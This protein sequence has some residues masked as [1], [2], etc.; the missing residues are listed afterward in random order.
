MS[1]RQ[2]WLRH[3]VAPVSGEGFSK[4]LARDF[5]PHEDL[6]S[7][8]TAVNRRW[9]KLVFV[10][11]TSVVSQL[12][13]PLFAIAGCIDLFIREV[14]LRWWLIGVGGGTLVGFAFAIVIAT[15]TYASVA[16]KA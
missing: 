11:A 3:F 2:N 4:L 6:W 16:R 5:W 1:F 12:S 14:P 15:L 8:T 9:L 10:Y 13:I 7:S